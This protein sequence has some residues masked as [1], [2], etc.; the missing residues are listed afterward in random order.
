MIKVQW[1]LC[2]YNVSTGANGLGNLK[3]VFEGFRSIVAPYRCPSFFV[4]VGTRIS[5]GE[6]NIRIII[7][8]REPE[9]GR[10]VFSS[11]P[12]RHHMS[13]EGHGE[14]FKIIPFAIHGLTLPEFGPYRYHISVNG[15]DVHASSFEFIQKR[16]G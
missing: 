6:D 7:S 4:V 2:C 5:V 11:D 1:S 8:T 16:L 3:G 9:G 12:T 15:S 10:V 13:V 14:T